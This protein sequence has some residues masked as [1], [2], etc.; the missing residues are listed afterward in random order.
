MITEGLYHLAETT[1]I[2]DKQQAGFR[3]GRACEDQIAR[4]IQ[5]IQ[6]V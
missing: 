2:L 3:K 5:A 4:V 1:G 6:E